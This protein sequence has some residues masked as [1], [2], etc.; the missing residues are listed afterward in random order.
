[1][2][3]MIKCCLDFPEVRD[4]EWEQLEPDIAAMQ[5][6]KNLP[7]HMFPERLKNSSQQW[8]VTHPPTS[9]IDNA[10]QDLI[11][12]LNVVTLSSGVF[13]RFNVENTP[14]NMVSM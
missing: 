12:V 10:L 4:D 11:I 14:W 13:Y 1:M 8:F 6:L 7:E 9:G 2:L 3:R 5:R